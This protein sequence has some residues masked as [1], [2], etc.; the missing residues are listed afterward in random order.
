MSIRYLKITLVDGT[1]FILR[2]TS[3]SSKFVRG[4][5]VNEEGDEVVPPGY[6]NRH[7]SVERTSITKAVEM[8]M[9]NKYA[10]LEA[11]P[12]KEPPPRA[13]ARKKSPAQLNREINEAL[14][15]RSAKE[16]RGDASLARRSKA[17]EVD[18]AWR[19]QIIDQI[20]R[21]AEENQQGP[22]DDRYYNVIVKR[23]TT[24]VTFVRSFF[25]EAAEAP[26]DAHDAAA[27]IVLP[28]AQALRLARRLFGG[29]P[30]IAG[31][32]QAEDL[33]FNMDWF[34]PKDFQ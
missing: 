4:Y 15:K 28:R 29:G 22:W 27:L 20:Q 3:E 6:Q 10:T 13:G 2:V 7:R 21:W 14:E 31:D 5:E 23:L 33:T 25:P 12:K 16:R 24:L 18:T 34:R 1:R 26:F 11:V 32:L 19:R 30:G 17:A 9:N 8:R